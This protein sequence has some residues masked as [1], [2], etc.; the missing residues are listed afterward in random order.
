MYV[1]MHSD[2]FW[3]ILVIHE[4]PDVLI[5]IGRLLDSHGMRGLL[6]RSG[7]EAIG[8]AARQ[9][10]SINLIL[11]NHMIKGLSADETVNHVRGLRPGLPAL[12]MSAH[13]D[14]G[15]IRIDV[16]RRTGS[17][18]NRSGTLIESIREA[19]AG[20]GSALGHGA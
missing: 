15:V 16:V 9:F 4:D 12:Y 11:I 13:I 19:I 1:F 18:D 8:L 7:T 5:F 10:V 2:S 14:R 6:A 3:S 17:A 20:G